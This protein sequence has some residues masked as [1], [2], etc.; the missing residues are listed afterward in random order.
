MTAP[1]ST[2]TIWT[3]INQNSDTTLVPS[4]IV[5]LFSC[6]LSVPSPSACLADR[7]PKGRAK[8]RE[9]HQSFLTAI[10]TRIFFPAAL[11]LLSY[12]PMRLYSSVLTCERVVA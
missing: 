9:K 2:A 1:L 12:Q 8:A 5:S 10:S 4:G 6:N 3:Y 11:P 7:S